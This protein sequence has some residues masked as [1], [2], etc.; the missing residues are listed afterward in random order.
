M[1]ESVLWLLRDV[2]RARKQGIAAIEQRQRARLAE[3][4][5]FARA[6]SPYYRELYEKLPERV[7]DPTLLPITSKKASGAMAN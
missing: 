7:E 3:L 1:S 4:V 5:A 6:N 2:R